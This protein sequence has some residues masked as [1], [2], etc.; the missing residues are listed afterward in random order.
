MKT[1]L[2]ALTLA[3]AAALLITPTI[4]T[5]TQHE[6]VAYGE[7]M[8]LVPNLEYLGESRITTVEYCAEIEGINDYTDLVTD[9]E[10]EN[11]ESCLIE[12]T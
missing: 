10:F 5:P 1:L 11:M 2:T 6:I 3:T 12:H 9:D 7:T 8:I 4:A